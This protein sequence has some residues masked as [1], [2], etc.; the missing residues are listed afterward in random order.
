MKF[1]SFRPEYTASWDKEPEGRLGGSLDIHVT[2]PDAW[3]VCPVFSDGYTVQG[4]HHLPLFK[5]DVTQD[6]LKALKQSG[7]KVETLQVKLSNEYLIVS[8]LKLQ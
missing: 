7:C 2:S 4:Y 8:L 5:G 6:V 1:Y 3:S